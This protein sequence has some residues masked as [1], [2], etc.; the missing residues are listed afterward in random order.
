MALHGS[1]DFYCKTSLNIKHIPFIALSESKKKRRGKR[2]LTERLF[3]LK[4]QV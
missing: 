2:I 1:K 3:A 4:T